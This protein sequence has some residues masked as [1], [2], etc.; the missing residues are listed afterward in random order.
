MISYRVDALTSE[1]SREIKM[2]TRGLL[3]I[4]AILAT[5]AGSSQAAEGPSGTDRRLVAA[6]RS[7]LAEG[8]TFYA[9]F[10][11]AMLHRGADAVYLFNQWNRANMQYTPVS[12]GLKRGDPRLVMIKDEHREALT[13]T[14]RMET[15]L[16][17]PR[18]HIISYREGPPRGAANPRQLPRNLTANKP[19]SFVLASGPA[20]KLGKVTLRIGIA[21]LKADGPDQL[22]AEVNAS[23]CRPT[24]DFPRDRP[25]A[26]MTIPGQPND[27]TRIAPRVVQFDVPTK[28]L[29]DG[30]NRITVQTAATNQPRIVWVEILIENSYHHP[31][32]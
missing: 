24:A 23:P 26:T 3:A 25:L 10:T 13:T 18:R 15:A 22:T 14:G 1:Q 2:P 11:A 9:D 16:S 29:Q 27:L 7:D 5:L 8:L 4:A 17:L 19:E 28:A 21:G 32:E 31:T 6:D 12:P 20:R 30:D